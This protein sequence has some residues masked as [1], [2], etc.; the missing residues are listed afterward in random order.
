M[1]RKKT[2]NYVG[3]RALRNQSLE[4]TVYYV[5]GNNNSAGRTMSLLVK[6]LL[7]MESTSRK[8]AYF[9]V[10]AQNL[11]VS[12]GADFLIDRYRRL[13]NAGH[14][15]KGPFTKRSPLFL[16][17]RMMRLMMKYKNKHK[18]FHKKLCFLTS[19][20]MQKYELAKKGSVLIPPY[21]LKQ[22]ALTPKIT[23]SEILRR[24]FG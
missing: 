14:K 13:Y 17:K 20:Q 18:I 16:A 8:D 19:E 23:L 6:N 10:N 15:T 5:C 24:L 21:E 2:Y 22:N 12:G 11:S 1:K 9:I 4:N 3:Y 7:K